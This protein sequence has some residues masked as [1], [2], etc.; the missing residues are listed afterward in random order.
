MNCTNFP[1]MLSFYT[2]GKTE[3]TSN[4]NSIFFFIFIIKISKTYY[5]K[6]MVYENQNSKV[7][8]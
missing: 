6:Y 5:E 8:F 2:E 3:G 7:S 1:V 4:K